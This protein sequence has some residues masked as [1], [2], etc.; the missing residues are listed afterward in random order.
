MRT[1]ESLLAQ[2]FDDCEWLVIDGDSNDGTKA[3][4]E[5]YGAPFIS[6]PDRGLYDAMNKGIAHACGDYLFFLNAGDVF[7]GDGVLKA[8]A[9]QIAMADNPPDFIYGDSL[10]ERPG[11]AAAYKAARAHE[12]AALGM[13]THHQAMFYRRSLMD[14][15]R[16]DLAY[17]IA[18]DYK[19]TLRFLERCENILY[20]PF[21]VCLFESGGISQQKTALGRCEQFRIRKEL[22]VAGL[23]RNV[24]IILLQNAALMLRRFAPGVYWRLKR[25]S[26]GNNGN[27]SPQSESPQSR[28]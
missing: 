18:A 3:F 9:D 6:E 16:Y 27:D 14:D 10:E 4:L 17:Q 11:Q 13:F 23:L 2:D 21:P 19:L 1:R 28:P 15:L 12:K 26:S 22:G 5:E 8:L 20:V 7:A 25:R 24:F